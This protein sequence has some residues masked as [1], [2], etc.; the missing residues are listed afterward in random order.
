VTSFADIFTSMNQT[1]A[2]MIEFTHFLYHS[3]LQPDPI[4]LKNAIIAVAMKMN[5]VRVSNKSI[6]GPKI[7]EDISV[8]DF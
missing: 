8:A 5:D 3:S 7:A 1:I 6:I 4:I 2:L